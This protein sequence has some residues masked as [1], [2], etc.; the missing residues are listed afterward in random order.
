MTKSDPWI[1]EDFLFFY[2][3]CYKIQKN[4]IQ[5]IGSGKKLIQKFPLR[6]PFKKIFKKMQVI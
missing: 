5:K 4:L 6:I 3:Y 2:F 1:I